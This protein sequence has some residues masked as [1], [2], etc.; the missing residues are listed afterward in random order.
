MF[1]ASIMF[2]DFLE[3]TNWL[4]QRIYFV[5][6]GHLSLFYSF[7]NTTKQTTTTSTRIQIGFFIT[8]T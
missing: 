3:Y 6:F 8:Q 5:F 4:I 7:S 2:G 1:F